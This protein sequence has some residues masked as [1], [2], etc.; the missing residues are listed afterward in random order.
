MNV[1]LPSISIIIATYNSERTLRECLDS[2]KKQ[3]YHKKNIELIIADGGSTDKTLTIAKL[4]NCYIV[5]IPTHKQNAEYNKGVG[6]THAK[7]K[8]V[9]FI[10]HDNVLPHNQWLRNMVE[11]LLQHKNVVAVEPL[12]YHYSKKYNLLDRYFA[13]FGVNDPVPYYLG[14]ADRMDYIHEGY[15]L[16]GYIIH[17]G[18]E[19]ISTPDVRSNKYYIVEFDQK[20]PQ[21]IPTLGANGFLIRRKLLLKAKSGP[22]YFFHIDVN[23]DLVKQGFTKYAFIK[24]SIIH[25][26]NNRLIPFLSRRLQFIDEYYWQRIKYRR[27]NVYLSEDKWKLI[28]YV[29]LSLTFIKPAI[30]SIRGYF[31]IHDLAW[32]LHPFMCFV[33]TCIYGYGFLHKKLPYEN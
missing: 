7:N 21:R 26:T 15:N 4:F 19:Q 28:M 11:P 23:V 3:D 12:R 25:K 29:F 30:D 17:L 24:D 27:Y 16:L 31:K 18:S 2:L 6:L 10:D 9:L 13:L 1:K 33:F 22:E 8:L 14:K 32:F 5:K 20:H